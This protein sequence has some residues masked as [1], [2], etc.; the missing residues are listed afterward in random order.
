LFRL[1]PSKYITPNVPTS[2]SGTATLG[3][4]VDQHHGQHQ[5]EL[6]V[7]YGCANGFGA[8]GE[9]LHTHRRRQRMLQLWEQFLNAVRHR[10]NVCAGLSLHV[11]D[12]RRIQV[13]PCGLLVILGAVDDHRHVGQTDR[14][15]VLVCDH[16]GTV[17]G[18]RYQL[19][20]GANGERLPRS[21][22]HSLG[23]IDVGKANLRTQIFQAQSV[24]SQRGRVR[25]NTNGGLLSSA[26]GDQAN[27]RQL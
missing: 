14:R 25:L 24:G 21:V 12:H 1:Y 3:I 5:F 8:V 26:D 9:N 4:T 13:H 17:V 2:E 7:F 16:Q 27:A 23:L 10:D 11:H 18:A 15:S 20:V 22:N 19:I 6:N